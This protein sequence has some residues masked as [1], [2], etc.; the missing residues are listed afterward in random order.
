[1]SQITSL[2]RPFHYWDCI[3]HCRLNIVFLT[4]DCI[5]G[6]NSQPLLAASDELLISIV[7]EL[8]HSHWLLN[9]AISWEVY[10]GHT[11]FTLAIFTLHE[12]CY[13]IAF[14]HWHWYYYYFHYYYLILTLLTDY[15]YAAKDISPAY[16]RRSC[17]GCMSAVLRHCFSLH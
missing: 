6:F 15:T 7:I 9:I 1:M 3:G 2:S 8:S 10:W 12:Y 14:C 17:K 16:Y 4:Y 11:H 5:E 13:W